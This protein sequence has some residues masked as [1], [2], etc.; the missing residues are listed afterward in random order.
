MTMGPSS[1]DWG[2]IFFQTSIHRAL[3][4]DRLY[5]SEGEG[6]TS[7]IEFS[8]QVPLFFLLFVLAFFL[9]HNLAVGPLNLLNLFLDPG[10]E[11]NFFSFFKEFKFNPNLLD[12]INKLNKYIF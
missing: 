10:M 12:L 3:L 9:F 11:C 8:F 7:Q 6:F 2:Q 4:S 1:M 5:H